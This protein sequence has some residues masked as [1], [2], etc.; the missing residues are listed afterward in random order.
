MD[1]PTGLKNLEQAL[2]LGGAYLD[3]S[4]RAQAR[5]V[6]T[7][8]RQRGLIG[9]ERTVVALAGATGSG[10]SSLLNAIV[11]QEVAGVAA[12]RPATR[13]PLGVS[14]R[15]ASD[16][17]DWLGVRERKVLLQLAPDTTAN[18]VLVDLP[19][20][21]STADTHRVQAERIIARADVVIWVLDPQK[22]ADAV[23]HE[24]FLAAMSEYHSSLL[25]VINQVDRLGAG[26]EEAIVADLGRI[27]VTEG[28]SADIVA[29]SALTGRG[30]EE[31]RGALVEIAAGKRA[32]AE[33]LA[34]DVRTAGAA[35]TENL[36][37]Q[38]GYPR[39]LTDIAGVDELVSGLARA[40]GLSSAA[41]EAAG[42]YRR[43]ARRATAWP[44][45]RG[46]GRRAL[47]GGR[48]GSGADIMRSSAAGVTSHSAATTDTG[49]RPYVA[50][51]VAAV[52][53]SGA[54]ENTRVTLA[55][56][57]TQVTRFLPRSWRGAVR[58][59][60]SRQAARLADNIARIIARE[61]QAWH[62]PRWWG[63]AAALQWLAF[64]ALMLGALGLAA[65]IITEVGGVTLP[66]GLR[67]ASLICLV[68]GSVC[69]VVVSMSARAART[70]G[71][72]RLER[73]VSTRARAAIE[74]E[75]RENVLVPFRTEMERYRDFARAV[76][77]LMRVSA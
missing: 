21:D 6:L 8:A 3:E 58:D 33:K 22:Y 77:S 16:V 27:L 40:G 23:V 38:G 32:A 57:T 48:N 12:T 64:A 51:S 1:L 76:A 17:L 67:R 11:G 74:T 37:Y 19:D 36:I 26:D 47:P 52:A 50:G 15:H 72:Q 10:K 63:C 29:A 41:R 61:S 4:V 73:Q 66:L 45:L 20:I 71:A 46:R 44:P 49:A 56:F 62:R 60:S 13:A 28:V 14:G 54:V 59:E 24:D 39:D 2:D 7:R 34:A 25:I 31:I 69:G 65:G 68:A 9:T 70:R 55:E 75:V 18:L 43:A 5:D 30:I 42:H 35:L 53:S